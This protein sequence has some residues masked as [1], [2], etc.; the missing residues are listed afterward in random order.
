MVLFLSALAALFSAIA[1]ILVL[2]Q[3]KGGGSVGTERLEEQLKRLESVL[4]EEFSGNR[5]ESGE[6]AQSQRAELAAVFEGFRKQTDELEV[7][8][9]RFRDAHAEL[10]HR[11]EQSR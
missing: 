10:G 9:A 1:C 8:G 11:P 5:K 3:S 2:T 4:R 7:R 6:Q